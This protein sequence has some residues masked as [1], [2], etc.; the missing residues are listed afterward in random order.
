MANSFANSIKLVTAISLLASPSGATIKKL[1]TR[2]DISRRTAFRLLTA[3]EEL[4]IPLIDEQPKPRIEKTY[5]IL[6]SYII[7]LPNIAIL[8]P[9]FTREEKDFL[10]DMLDSRHPGEQPEKAFLLNSIR[11]KLAALPPKTP[12]HFTGTNGAAV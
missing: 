6:D 1:M 3:L 7:K 12:E 4:G 2:L 10:L 5:R 11:Q 8:N 9:G